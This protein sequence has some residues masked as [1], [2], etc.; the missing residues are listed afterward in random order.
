MS[1]FQVNP[2]AAE[3]EG[4]QPDQKHAHNGI[5]EG[6]QRPPAADRER[7]PFVEAA[8]VQDP[9]PNIG[10][11]ITIDGIRAENQPEII[12]APELFLVTEIIERTK[13][14]GA[15]VRTLSYS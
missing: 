4:A 11:D 8:P 10:D 2:L 15:K 9:G 6:P 7:I 12:V 1:K 5:G 13:Q 3:R 14:K